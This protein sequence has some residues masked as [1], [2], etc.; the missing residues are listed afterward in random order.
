MQWEI[1]NVRLDT[2][3]RAIERGRRGGRCASPLQLYCKLDISVSVY[4]YIIIY[5]PTMTQRIA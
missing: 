1:A 5:M 2:C 3:V 4:L